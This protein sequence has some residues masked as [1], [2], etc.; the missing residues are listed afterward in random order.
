MVHI[1]IDPIYARSV[2]C[3]NLKQSLI[4]ELKKKRIHFSLSEDIEHM[5]LEDTVF[6]IASDNAWTENVIRK[7]N[8]NSIQPILLCNQMDFLEGLNYSCVCSDVY[9]SMKS[10]FS[11][12][13]YHGK[14]SPV[15][16]GLNKKSLSDTGTLKCAQNLSCE[17]DFPLKVFYNHGSLAECFEQFYSEIE[18][19]DSAIC[20]NDFAAVSLIKH[21]QDKNSALL[22]QLLI[23][24]CAKS[25]ISELYPKIVSP[26]SNYEDYGKAAVYI[27]EKIEKHHFISNM[28]I[29]IA[30]MVDSAI[31]DTTQDIP[32][33]ETLTHTDEFYQDLEIAEMICVEKLLCRCDQTDREIIDMLCQKVTLDE[34]CE[35][36]FLSEST[37]KYRIRRILE[38]CGF[39][40]K[41]YLLYITQKY[42]PEYK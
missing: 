32:F 25:E 40:T 24:S 7:L 39:Y 31:P 4:S 16:Y 10:I 20:V 41:D 21:L 38:D 5:L 1:L 22:E 23:F 30:R 12:I 11:S 36:C 6:L 19:F 2:W 27:S 3:E 15:I 14:K 26:R 8:H 28:T 37:I 9:G 35:K 17:M 34:I 33:T 13:K 42:F 18:Y 29:R